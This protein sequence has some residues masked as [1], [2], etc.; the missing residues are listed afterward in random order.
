MDDQLLQ[1]AITIATK[2][3]DGQ[4]DKYGAPYIRHITRVMNAGTTE[5]KR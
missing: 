5:M 1:K 2:A 3:H 4:L